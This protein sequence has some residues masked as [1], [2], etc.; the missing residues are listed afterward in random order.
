MKSWKTLIFEKSDSYCLEENDQIKPL[1]YLPFIN[2]INIFIGTNN[3]GKSKFMRDIMSLKELSIL[4]ETVFANINANIDDYNR[5]RNRI[6]RLKK[7][8]GVIN[9]FES[10]RNNMYFSNRIG[11]EAKIAKKIKKSDFL[12]YTYF[13]NCSFSIRT[14][15][16][17]K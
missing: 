11:S 12:L 3:S 10:L 15:R 5:S 16:I 14:R 2:D 4:D 7:Y 1:Q 9:D 6:S 13:K 8:S 17:S